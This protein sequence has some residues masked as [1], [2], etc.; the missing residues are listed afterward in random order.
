MAL[1]AGDEDDV[2]GICG[3]LYT[4]CCTRL[5]RAYDFGFPYDGNS[6]GRR[7]HGHRLFQS[8]PRERIIPAGKSVSFAY[9]PFAIGLLTSDGRFGVEVSAVPRVQ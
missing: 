6:A 8:N 5:S 4:V 7:V 1:Q 9:S 2:Y 3:D